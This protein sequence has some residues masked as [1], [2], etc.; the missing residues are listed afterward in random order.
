MPVHHAGGEIPVEPLTWE[1]IMLPEPLHPSI[2]HLPIALTLLLPFFAIG[3]LWAIRKGIHPLR[4]WGL[5][6][7]LMAALVGSA[8]VALE[9]GEKEEDRVE[10]VV[11]ESFIETHEE[12]ASAFLL[13]TGGVLA[14]A[15][16]GLGRGK[17]SA[18]A[19]II[20]TAG[21][22]ALVVMGVRVGHSGG[23]LVY[24]HGAANAYIGSNVA[25]EYDNMKA[26]PTDTRRDRDEDD[27]RD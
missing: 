13:L 2:V 20:G 19:R 14:V 9:T 6:T 21:T 1:D 10:A 17:I 26:A 22:L 18:T 27:H 11:N 16:L 25:G 4:A 5:T 24:R 7:V 23:E 15:V 12:A 3:A 8:W